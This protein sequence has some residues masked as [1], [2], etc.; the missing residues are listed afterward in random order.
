VKGFR[1]P[2]RVTAG[3]AAALAAAAALALAP[4]LTGSVERP[5]VNRVASLEA[6][7]D[8]GRVHDHAPSRLDLRRDRAMRAR[9]AR[10]AYRVANPSRCPALRGAARRAFARRLVE[11]RLRTTFDH[12]PASEIG[13]WTGRFQMNSL[14]INAI[15][16]PTGKV[17]WWAYP[18]NPSLLPADQRPPINYT[19]TYVWDPA[20][21]QSVSREAPIDPATGRP[22]NI[23]CSGQTFLRDG[24]LL[25]AG[26][27]LAY[28]GTGT[29]FR[30]LDVVLTFNPF[31]ET[32]TKQPDLRDGRWY[33]TL[34]LLPDGRVVIVGGLDSSGGGGSNNPD[35]EVFTPSPDPNGVGAIERKPSAARTFGLYPHLLLVPG[36]KLLLAGPGRTDTALLDTASWTWRDVTD[37]PVRREWGSATLLPGGPGGPTKLMLNGGSNTAADYS[38]APATN[39]SLVADIPSL[40][41]NPT[42]GV[43]QPG[44]SQVRGRSHLN[45][46]ILP[47]GT[48]LTTGGGLG[49]SGGSLF[50]GPVFTAELW[51]PATNA[52]SEL[53]A[54][55]DA[56][57]YH[58]T[59]LL[60]PDGRVVSAGDDRSEH[61]PLG[62]RTYEFFSPHYLYRGA[63]PGIFSAP[64]GVPYGASF[65]VGTAEGAG[66]VQVSLLRLGATTH[67][68]DT[69]QRLLALPFA[70]TPG[71]LVTTMPSDPTAAP[72]GFYQL[73]LVS[74]TGAVSPGRMVR[75]DAGFPDPPDVP[76]PAAGAGGRPGAGVAARRKSL[77]RPPKIK[78]LDATVR[79]TTTFGR[80]R[81]TVRSDR[82]FVGAIK[83]LPVSRGNT[84]KRPLTSKAVKGPARK[85][86]DLTAVFTRKRLGST[87]RMRVRLVVRDARGGRPRTLSDVVPLDRRG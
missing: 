10:P 39:T 75:L 25:V 64:G 49:S 13:R 66:V 38:N 29:D 5:L 26:G 59:S 14:A 22:Y 41:A 58:S 21:G 31:T 44:P 36:G 76:A 85:T 77:R 3:I 35:V 27:N 86:V 74:N 81:V 61:Q 72:P 70:Q 40:L 67:A 82:K 68:L 69:D 84:A 34:T 15:L 2:G 83:L 62:A 56:R 23:W 4:L 50:P 80:I 1:R 53:D 7:G 9:C 78:I 24:R 52:W 42:G 57:T 63:R 54:Q 55:V 33:P 28:S 87:I 71:G 43:W 11:A 65:G 17:L 37:L 48:L 60:L 51:N 18:A 20:T 8:M 45:T 46:T 32:W 30:G 79:M 6:G 16:L 47:D 19:E 73:F 12:R